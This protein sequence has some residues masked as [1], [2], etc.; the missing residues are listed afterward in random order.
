MGRTIEQVD[1]DV[2]LVDDE[3]LRRLR[4]EYL[5]AH[6]TPSY[7][8]PHAAANYARHRERFEALAGVREAIEWWGPAYEIEQGRKLTDREQMKAF[9]LT[10]GVTTLE[11]VSLKRADADALR[12]K[13]LDWMELKGFTIP[14]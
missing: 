8:G 9:Y 11:A 6:T 7:H 12:K 10:F 14:A 2:T 4:G 13:L 5:E 1:G 3:T